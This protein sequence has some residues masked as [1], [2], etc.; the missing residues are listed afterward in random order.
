MIIIRYFINGMKDQ[1]LI[2]QL[3]GLPMPAYPEDSLYLLSRNSQPQKG[4]NR[5][6]TVSLP[7]FFSS[8]WESTLIHNGKRQERHSFANLW[9]DCQL[10]LPWNV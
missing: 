5:N 10:I 6:K 9:Q 8:Q 4:Y 3:L 7:H 2:S 1:P